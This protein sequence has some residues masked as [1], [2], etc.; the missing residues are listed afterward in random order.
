MLVPALEKL[1]DL[2]LLS[3]AEGLSSIAMAG[4][5]MALAAVGITLLGVSLVVLAAGLIAVG[6]AIAL[7]VASM[8]LV[9]ATMSVFTKGFSNAIALIKEA[10]DDL[11]K[12][13][14]KFFQ[15]LA[16]MWESSKAKKIIDAV[17]R[18]GK[19]LAGKKGGSSGLFGGFSSEL[20]YASPPKVFLEFLDAVGLTFDNEG[21]GAIAKAFNWG[22]NVGTGVGMGLW[23][24][25]GAYVSSFVNMLG[26]LF[27]S[28]GRITNK[29]DTRSESD[30]KRLRNK[31]DDLMGIT[32]DATKESKGLLDMFTDKITDALDLNF[33]FI[34]SENFLAEALNG[35]TDGFEGAAGAA[36][37]Y[38]DATEKAGKGSKSAK[39]FIKDLTS[40]LEGQMNIFQKFEL[41]TEVTAEQML[42]NMRSNLDAFASWSHRMAVLAERGIDQALYQKLAEMGPTA[43]ETV[44]AFVQMTDEQLQEANQLFTASLVMPA[45]AADVVGQGYAYCGEMAAQ[46]WSN[47]LQQHMAEHSASQK[48]M[49]KEV[50]DAAEVL[51]VQSPSTVFFDLAVN[52]LQGYIN[53]LMDE[54]MLARLHTVIVNVV[55]FRILDD[56]RSELNYDRFHSIAENA[57][58]GLIDGINSKAGE[59]IAAAEA[60]AS[61]IGPIM[62]AALG[63]HSPS[64]VTRQIG[65][66][67]SEGLTLGILDGAHNVEFAANK[68]ANNAIDVMFET[69][70]RVQDL[71]NSELDFNPTITPMLDLS[72]MRAQLEEANA[73]FGNRQAYLYGVQNGGN[74][75]GYGYGGAPQINYTQNNYSPKALSRVEIYRQTQNQLNTMKGVVKANA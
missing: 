11:K 37:D 39:D 54:T 43:Y 24:K 29:Y 63:E 27:G 16:A 59:A 12:K 60:I 7:F 52:C 28:M 18:F 46:G 75:Y 69:T 70:N 23:E 36:G 62:M 8:G 4:L 65:A 56:F 57:V 61:A 34:D 72:Y 15:D 13:F 67:A 50:N 49:E 71:I 5:K 3:I 74:P 19:K 58:Q 73:M 1:K 20:G 45:K 53:G 47:A 68:V 9:V 14:N 35:V 25:G 42:E 48:V 51:G 33:D 38:A 30:L 21:S 66:Y 22:S 6:A 44:N 17:T 10:I 32:N 64:K 2:P 40:T 41:K 55:C 26:G 31:T